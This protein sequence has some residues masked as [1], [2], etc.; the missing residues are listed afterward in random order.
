MIYVLP[1]NRIPDID[2]SINTDSVTRYT[3]IDIPDT[4]AL[5]FPM[6]FRKVPTR[7]Q[8]GDI[9]TSMA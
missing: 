9:G 8:R 4:D 6:H 1:N 2:M 5:T 3:N 7:R